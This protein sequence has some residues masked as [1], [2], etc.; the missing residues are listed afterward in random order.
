MNT[1]SSMGEAEGAA[2]AHNARMAADLDAVIRARRA[3]TTDPF[4]GH[5]VHCYVREGSYCSCGHTTVLGAPKPATNNTEES[6]R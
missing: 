2:M 3:A 4:E 5:F 6:P 1:Y